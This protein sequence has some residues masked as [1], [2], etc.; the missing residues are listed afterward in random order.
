MRGTELLTVDEVPNKRHAGL[1][2][3]NGWWRVTHLTVPI[4]GMR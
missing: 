2:C 1:P 4:P 3:A